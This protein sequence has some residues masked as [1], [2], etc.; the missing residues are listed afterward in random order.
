MRDALPAM[1]AQWRVSA[2]Q[3]DARRCDRMTLNRFAWRSLRGGWHG[4]PVRNPLPTLMFDL[5]SQGLFHRGQS[6]PSQ[7]DS[8]KSAAC[9]LV[10]A[11]DDEMDVVMGC[12]AVNR[13]DPT[14]VADPRFQFQTADGGRCQTKKVEPAGAFRRND[15]PV[16]GPPAIVHLSVV[17]AKR[18]LARSV[19]R[20][21]HEAGE[22]LAVFA[23]QSAGRAEQ[24]RSCRRAVAVRNVLE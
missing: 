20:I 24:L 23:T 10:H 15:Q 19:K 3:M 21:G 7:V 4:R 14:Q 6:R 1:R 5:M 13:R 2:N 18:L 16:D 22:S 9:V 11:S 17:S 8:P 12:V